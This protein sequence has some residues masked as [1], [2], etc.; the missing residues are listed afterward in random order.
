MASDRHPTARQIA[1]EGSAVEKCDS[2][3]IQYEREKGFFFHTKQYG[4]NDAEEGAL[5][6]VLWVVF[7]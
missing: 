7:T 2:T 4:Q 6:R 5:D 3:R 1:S